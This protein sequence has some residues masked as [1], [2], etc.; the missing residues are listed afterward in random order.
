MGRPKTCDETLAA[1]AREELAKNKEL[2]V[3]IRLQAIVSSAE[4]PI[5]TVADVMGVGRDTVWRWIK[6]FRENGVEGLVDRPKGHNPP[7]LNKDELAKIAEWLKQG[8]NQDGEKVHW[9]LARL[10][11]EV[12]GRFGKKVGKTPLWFMVRKMG[13]RQKVP[14]P[15][16]A[17]AD[18]AAQE[19]FKK[20][21]RKS[22]GV[23]IKK[24]Q[25]RVL[26]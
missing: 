19:S 15:T 24:Q 5:S 21:F 8:R 25:R 20:N 2:R 13:F 4:Q 17:K 26:L 12:R 7:K 11:D 3:G 6:R 10:R 22:G 9:T 16:H 14:R 18:P 1:R 23:S